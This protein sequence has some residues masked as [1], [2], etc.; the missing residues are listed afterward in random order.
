MNDL[1]AFAR[2][3][4]V[5][6]GRAGLF[7]LERWLD[8]NAVRIVAACDRDAESRRRAE[9]LCGRLTQ[10]AAE[11]LGITEMDAVFI[12]VPAPRRGDLAR[13]VLAAGKHLL[14]ESP[15]ADSLREAQSLVEAARAAGR[16]IVVWSHGREEPDFRTAQHVLRSGAI[17]TPR[18][19]RFEGWEPA[20]VRQAGEAE[21]VP[22]VFGWLLDQLVALSGRPAA[23]AF[24]VP[25]AGGG[26]SAIVTFRDGPAAT[27]TWKTSASA[28]LDHGWAVDA[29]HGGYAAGRRWVRTV[30]GEV[31]ELPAEA[32]QAQTIEDSLR[33]ALAGRLPIPP[34]IEP[35][36]LVAL[37][38]AAMRSLRTRAVEPVEE[39]P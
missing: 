7:A 10:D 20:A 22:A 39:T 34:I 19:L 37:S 17:G 8:G 1:R 12:A 4:V 27:L 33:H 32:P 21:D 29:D 35:L 25:L 5:G 3:G 15:L 30:E 38:A 9:T 36:R 2:I 31:Y 14:I 6:L 23:T 16:Q 24:A 13:Q 18:L 28:R 11:L 26:L